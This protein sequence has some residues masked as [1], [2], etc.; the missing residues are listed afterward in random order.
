MASTGPSK[1]A[2]I[3][4]LAEFGKAPSLINHTAN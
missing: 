1:S 4:I 3:A 2:K